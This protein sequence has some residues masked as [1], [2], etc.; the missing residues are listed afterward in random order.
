M[1]QHSRLLQAPQGPTRG[2]G[3][4]C[5]LLALAFTSHIHHLRVHL[6]SELHCIP[7]SAEAFHGADNHHLETSTHHDDH[8]QHQPHPA[9][10]HDVPL[11]GKRVSIDV[12]ALFLPPDTVA[13]GAPIADY[14]ELTFSQ[15]TFSPAD[16]FSAPTNPRGPPAA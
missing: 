3:W 15:P 13:P 4:L 10:E 2:W 7:R 8:H 11:L 12:L 5:V 16:T 1:N 14:H 6:Q 9:S